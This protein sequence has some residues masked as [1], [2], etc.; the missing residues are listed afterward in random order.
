MSRRDALASAIVR[1][2]RRAGL[3]ERLWFGA[4]PGLLNLR[5]LR[6]RQLCHAVA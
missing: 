3:G 4:G 6:N 5:L 1:L 2:F